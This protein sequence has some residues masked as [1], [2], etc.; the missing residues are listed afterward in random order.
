MTTISN[1]ELAT[2]GATSDP[3]I[4]ST[5]TG[6]AL[7]APQEVLDS[8]PVEHLAELRTSPAKYNALD[9]QESDTDENDWTYIYMIGTPPFTPGGV[10]CNPF[11]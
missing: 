2:T 7:E 6:L 4:T 1:G 5:D 11:G 9:G 3:Y 8:L 10:G